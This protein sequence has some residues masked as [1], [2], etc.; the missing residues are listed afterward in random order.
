M[1]AGAS[2]RIEFA[3]HGHAA[4]LLTHR[5]VRDALFQK[6][7][8]Q[9]RRHAAHPVRGFDLNDQRVGTV[10]RKHHAAHVFAHHGP[11]DAH[12]RGLGVAA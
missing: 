12:G 7:L 6:F 11:D 8:H 1:R 10:G 4:D 5:A 3:R 9:A 2:G